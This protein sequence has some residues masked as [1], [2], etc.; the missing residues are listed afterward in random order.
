VEGGG[1]GVESWVLD[2]ADL[3]GI[4]EGKGAGVAV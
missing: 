1:G 2:E 3:G 4:G